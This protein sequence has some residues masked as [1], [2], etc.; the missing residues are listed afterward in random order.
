MSIKEPS[1]LTF[2][3][4]KKLFEGEQPKE[5]K[6]TSSFKASRK[7][8]FRK[9]FG[10]F[11]IGSDGKEESESSP[12][13][14]NGTPKE[15]SESSSHPPSLTPS[16]S[17]ILKSESPNNVS[18]TRTAETLTSP[19]KVQPPLSTESIQIVEPIQFGSE[20]VTKEKVGKFFY[21]Y[22]NSNNYKCSIKK[23]GFIDEIFKNGKEFRNSRRSLFSRKKNK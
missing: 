3:S 12:K 18:K 16:S 11:G 14:G 10:N 23:S 20:V 13:D 22:S 15:N 8:A 19:I 6:K 21:F 7:E 2:R 5:V 4:K 17:F 1:K 9:A